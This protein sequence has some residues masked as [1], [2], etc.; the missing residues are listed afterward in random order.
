MAATL[1]GGGAPAVVVSCCG[2]AAPSDV[3]AA[4]FIRSHP[5]GPYTSART[6]GFWSVLE[7]EAHVE[8][9]AQ[10]TTLMLD[11]ASSLVPHR[12]VPLLT[13]AAELRPR[14]MACVRR[15]LDCWAAVHGAGT[16]T[17]LKLTLLAEW[18]S[19][20]AMEA[21]D[22]RGAR[23][24]GALAH[25]RSRRR[26]GCTGFHARCTLDSTWRAARAAHPRG[27]HWRAAAQR[28][29]EG[30]R[31]GQVMLPWCLSDCVFVC[32]ACATACVCVC[33]CVCVCVFVCVCVCVE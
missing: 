28:R 22:V 9:I 15:G 8:R 32:V 6:V 31:L 25:A 14:M 11:D 17:E 29:R 13:S 20:A 5:R 27:D 16:G 12:A 24:G 4:S 2:S 33:L 30:Q 18:A 19:P 10:S 3:S 7:F 1:S 26:C 21:S 23:R